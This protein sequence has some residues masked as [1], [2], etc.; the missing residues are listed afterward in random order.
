MFCSRRPVTAIAFLAIVGTTSLPLAAWEIDV[1]YVL[2]CWLAERAGFSRNDA[3]EIAQADQSIDDSEHHAAIPTM[4]WIILSG[5]LGAAQDL[6]DHHFPSGARLPSPPESRV[7]RPGDV[8]AREA[9]DSALRSG[10]TEPSLRKLGEALH[11]FQ[12]SWSHQG[13]PD[14]PLGLRPRLSCAHP[15]VRGGWRSH[16]A[17]LTYLHEEEVVEQ[18]RQTYDIFQRFLSVYPRFRSHGP[19]SWADLEPLVH[20]FARAKTK[21]DKDAWAVKSI[22]AGPGALSVGL[23]LDGGRENLLGHTI[24]PRVK[25]KDPAPPELVD[26]ARRV[27]EAWFRNSEYGHCH[28]LRRLVAAR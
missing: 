21:K 12:D 20:E 13:V 28:C 26:S 19:Q 22:D 10:Q 1:H 2:T 9:V 25:S 23:T 14:I 24:R 6:Q 4:A 18:A 27:G 16:D 5:D 8:W 7:V 3:H 15:V 17:D 11:P